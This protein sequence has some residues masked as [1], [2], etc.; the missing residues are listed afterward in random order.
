[1]RTTAMLGQVAAT[2]RRLHE[3]PS[4]H[5]TFS[6]FG[7]VETYRDNARWLG[8]ELPEAFDWSWERAEEMRAAL[9]A[10]PPA[11]VPVPQRPPERELP[12]RGTAG[13]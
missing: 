12:A 11:A 4:V 5:A 2:L 1:M 6:A 8:V 3:G 7:I 10:D 13:C 9:A